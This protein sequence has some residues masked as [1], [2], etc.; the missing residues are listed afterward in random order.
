MTGDDDQWQILPD[1]NSSNDE[2][3]NTWAPVIMVG[4][5]ALAVVLICLICGETI[6]GASSIIWGKS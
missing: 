3:V 2:Y 6:T 1:T 4:V 5:M